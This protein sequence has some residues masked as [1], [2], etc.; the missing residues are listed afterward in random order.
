MRG[1]GK[2]IHLQRK[3]GLGRLRNFFLLGIRRLMKA[4][5]Q[6]DALRKKEA[7]EK[8]GEREGSHTT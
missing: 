2:A 1:G 8:W 5:N 6:N 7:A 3:E 4:K